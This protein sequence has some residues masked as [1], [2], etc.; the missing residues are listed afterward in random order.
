MKRTYMYS[1][2][3]LSLTFFF[4]GLAT[5]INI[6]DN[7]A[8][9]GYIGDGAFNISNQYNPIEIC[10]NKECSDKMNIIYGQSQSLFAWGNLFVKVPDG[11]DYVF[12]GRGDNEFFTAI[13]VPT[14]GIWNVSIQPRSAVPAG[15]TPIAMN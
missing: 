11:A 14:G 9:P 6:Y 5:Q 3:L 4:A 1:V 8:V 13:N 10:K 12:Q 2:L 7:Y 15:V